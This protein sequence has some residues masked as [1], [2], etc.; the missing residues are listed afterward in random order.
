MPDEMIVE[1]ESAWRKDLIDLYNTGKTATLENNLLG[2]STLKMLNDDYMQLQTTE[3]SVIEL[4]RLPLINNSYIICLVTTVYA[5]VPD[6]SVKFFTT[7][8]QP[9]QSDALLKPVEREWFIKDDAP[10]NT[11][12]VIDIEL[13]KYSLNA[14][15]NT[16]TAELTTPEYFDDETKARIKP[17]LKETPRIFTWKSGYYE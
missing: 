9:L 8:W 12:A 3:R 1:L 2:K 11:A 17:F 14:D 4:R 5:P 6:S 13:V 16:L 10:A 15:D 7:S